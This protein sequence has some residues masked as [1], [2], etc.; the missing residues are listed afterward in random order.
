MFMRNCYCFEEREA[1]D[2][3]IKGAYFRT[4]NNCHFYEREKRQK[5][6]LNEIGVLRGLVYA[7]ES[8]GITLEEQE[9]QEFTRLID[10]QEELKK[11]N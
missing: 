9:Y 6:L 2:S 8:I 1:D 4:L 3:T 11:D 10:I 5:S 7:L